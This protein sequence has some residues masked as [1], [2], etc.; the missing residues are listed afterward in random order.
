MDITNIL[1]FNVAQRDRM[2]DDCEIVESGL[3]AGSTTLP[4][5]DE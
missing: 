3:R 4:G 1:D 5:T 2:Y